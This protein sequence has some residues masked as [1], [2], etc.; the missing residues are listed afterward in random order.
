[1]FDAG[2]GFIGIAKK[3]PLA[4]S[5]TTIARRVKELLS[6]TREVTDNRLT[7]E[8]DAIPD[9]NAFLREIRDA[10]RVARFTASFHGP[11][12]FDAD[13]QFQRPMSVYL[14]AAEGSKGRTQID[15]ANLNKETLSA[16]TRSTASTGNDAA[17]R[18]QRNASSGL[19][20]VRMRG[21]VVSASYEDES[22]DPKSVL[23]DL[24]NKYVEVRGNDGNST[25]GPGG[26]DTGIQLSS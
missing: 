10:L 8:V 12:P 14:A 4:N 17:A 26:S 3:P 20:T 11:N 22:H 21:G 7:V 19:V 2:Y 1:V 13:L 9:P 5:T 6:Y 23:K 16:V 18:I 24:R 25:L 15:G